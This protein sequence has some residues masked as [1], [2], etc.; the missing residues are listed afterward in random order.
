MEFAR[1]ARQKDVYPQLPVMAGASVLYIV[2]A[3]IAPNPV[4]SGPWFLLL[5]TLL[6]IISASAVIWTRG[7]DDF[8]GFQATKELNRLDGH[9]GFNFYQMFVPDLLHEFELGVWKSIFTH[10]MRILY[11]HGQDRIN[12]LNSRFV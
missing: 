6:V 9:H 1:I 3:T 5:T 12:I 8:I 7:V 10:L 4:Q 11:V 2:L